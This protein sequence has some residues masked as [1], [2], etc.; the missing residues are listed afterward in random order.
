M[1]KDKKWKRYWNLFREVTK[2]WIY[3]YSFWER[4]KK[5]FQW[6]GISDFNQLISCLSVCS[7]FELLYRK[8]FSLSRVESIKFVVHK[9]VDR[10]AWAMSLGRDE[11][12]KE[13]SK[14]SNRFVCIQFRVKIESHSV[15]EII[16]TRASRVEWEGEIRESA[17]E[18]CQESSL[19]KVS[20]MCFH[21]NV[22]SIKL[23][24]WRR[25]RMNKSS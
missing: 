7:T 9:F 24:I 18:V 20:G 12:S 3:F 10:V 6:N 11:T 15:G 21:E 23:E 13:N 8:S 16:A 19:N 17:S 25:E 14:E 5:T 1:N 2:I 4:E 22:F